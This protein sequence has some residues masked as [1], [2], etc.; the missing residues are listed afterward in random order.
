MMKYDYL[1]AIS[2][3]IHLQ[4]LNFFSPLCFTENKNPWMKCITISVLNTRCKIMKMKKKIQ[5]KSLNAECLTLIWLVCL[6]FFILTNFK[7]MS[8]N[9]WRNLRS[10]LDIN[11][12]IQLNAFNNKKI[13]RCLTRLRPIHHKNVG[14]FDLRFYLQNFYVFGEVWLISTCNH[15]WNGC[16]FVN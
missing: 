7:Q 2:K 12:F 3:I 9:F 14:L 5:F 16:Q 11:Y 1:A 4:L 10:L 8:T 6:L 15:I 13:N